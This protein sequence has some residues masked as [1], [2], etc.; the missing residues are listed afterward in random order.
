MG[1][2]FPPLLQFLAWVWDGSKEQQGH[3]SYHRESLPGSDAKTEKAELS[4]WIWRAW[5]QLNL[6]LVI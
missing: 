4:P 1:L 5:I 2:S 3:P 6:K